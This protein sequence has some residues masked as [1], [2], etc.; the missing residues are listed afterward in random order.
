MKIENV[1][2]IGLAA[3]RLAGQ[4]RQFAV[5]GGVLGQIVDDDERVLAAVA[6]IFGDREASKWRDPLQPGG[7]RRRGDDED[8]ALGGA[9]LLHCVDDPLAPRSRAGRSPHRR[10]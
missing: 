6:K 5:G 1:A 10:R 9:V 7:G 4:Q 8:A 2:G 3:R